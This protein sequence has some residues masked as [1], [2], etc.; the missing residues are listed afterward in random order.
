VENEA[1]TQAPDDCFGM[2]RV[3]AAHVSRASG[4]PSDEK[5]FND[6]KAAFLRGQISRKQIE[7]AFG[8]AVDY[9]FRYYGMNKKDGVKH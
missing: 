4:Y 6:F 3:L 1:K 8:I 9:L 5:V 2:I 7:Y